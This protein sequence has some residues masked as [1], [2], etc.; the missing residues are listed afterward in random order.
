MSDISDPRP[1]LADANRS[2]H[3]R[4]EIANFHKKIVDE[5]REAVERDTVVVVGMAQ[6][7]FVK[8]ARAAL[9]NAGIP[10]TYKE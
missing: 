3:V 9:T 8:K 10:F 1:L 7:P 2:A 4:G 5:V 6:N